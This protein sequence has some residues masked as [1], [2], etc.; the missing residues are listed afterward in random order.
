MLQRKFLRGFSVCC[1]KDLLNMCSKRAQGPWPSGELN[2]LL[3]HNTQPP[4][5]QARSWLLGVF[6]RVASDADDTGAWSNSPSSRCVSGDRRK[7]HWKM[8]LTMA[9]YSVNIL[10][11]FIQNQSNKSYH[12]CR[13][14]PVWLWSVFI[15]ENCAHAFQLTLQL[16]KHQQAICLSLGIF[17]K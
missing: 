3:P 7:G 5:L 6:S 14:A 10:W 9:C 13:T 2:I 4:Q 17:N 1:Q 16:C 8:K 11:A 15:Q 12:P